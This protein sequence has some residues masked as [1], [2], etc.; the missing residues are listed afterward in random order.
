MRW[1]IC[2]SLLAITGC[3]SNWA[4]IRARSIE[5]SAAD[6]RAAV[7]CCK[8]YGELRFDPMPSEKALLSLDRSSQVFDFATGKSFL[9]AIALPEYQVGESLRVK[10]LVIGDAS[11]I[12]AMVMLYPIAT[13]LDAQKNEVETIEVPPAEYHSG[14]A[15]DTEG[16]GVGIVTIPAGSKFVIFHTA[17][18]HFGH[19]FNFNKSGAA[20]GIGFVIMTNSDFSIPFVATG[21]LRVRLIP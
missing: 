9:A 2:F 15:S 3:A 13:F 12:P 5:T 19:T 1:L 8:S 21:E 10:S 11:F 18:S 14:I 20:G 16:G 6:F 4:E 17:E 7:P